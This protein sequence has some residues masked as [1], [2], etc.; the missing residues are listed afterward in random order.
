MLIWIIAKYSGNVPGENPR[1]IESGITV[2]LWKGQ[3]V[4]CVLRDT[5]IRLFRF[6]LLAGQFSGSLLRPIFTPLGSLRPQ[7]S[8]QSRKG[9]LFSSV[10]HLECKFGLRTSFWSRYLCVHAQRLFE[11]VVRTA[12]VEQGGGWGLNPFP[13]PP[14]NQSYDFYFVLPYMCPVIYLWWKIVGIFSRGARLPDRVD[15]IFWGGGNTRVLNISLHG[16]NLHLA[17]IL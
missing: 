17:T 3:L 8:L 12:P 4:L 2:D 14:K 9:N 7:P 10:L 5:R 6:N 13:P 15:L 11:L 1:F 16:Q